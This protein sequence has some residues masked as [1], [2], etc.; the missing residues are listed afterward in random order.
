MSWCPLS[1]QSGTVCTAVVTS[2]SLTSIVAGLQLLST[3]SLLNLDGKGVSSLAGIMYS[4]PLFVIGSIINVVALS[5]GVTAAL[6]FGTF[7]AIILI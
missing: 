7:V 5:F 1:L 3:V 6:P 4:V 2:Y